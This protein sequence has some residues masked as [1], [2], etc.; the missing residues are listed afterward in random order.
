MRIEHIAIWT[1]NLELMKDFYTK[2]FQTSC[3]ELY[4]NTKTGFKSYFLN[5]DDG[6]RI[7]LMHR[8]DINLSADKYILGFAHISISVRDKEKVDLLTRNLER[9]GYKIHSQ[10]RITGDGYY[11]SVFLD[12]ENNLIELTI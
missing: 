12:P 9:D 1:Q 8:D 7:E 5:F 4:H 11:E 3:S 10:P 6:A 2:Y